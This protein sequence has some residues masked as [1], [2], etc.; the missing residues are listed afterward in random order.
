MINKVVQW[1]DDKFYPGVSDYWDDKLFRKKILAVLDSGSLLDLGAG[2]GILS[3]MNF[4]GIASKVT[5][6]DLDHRVLQNPY[7]DESHVVGG[8]VLPFQDEAFDVVV[9]DNVLEHLANPEQVFGEVQRVLRP[10][11]FFV[12]KTPNKSHYMPLIA[13]ITPHSFHEWFNRLRGRIEVDTFP[14][15]YRANSPMKIK[16]LA[17]KAG[18]EVV[19]IELIESRPEYL[20]FSAIPYFCGLIYERIVNSLPIFRLFRI[21]MIV[22]L[23][24]PELK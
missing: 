5:G 9:S 17:R 12:A 18:L 11:G 6:I 16:K 2:A 23:S 8:E 24:K 1:I 15:L 10:G 22:T 19:S 21:V 20:R 3:D 13:S 14:T 4:R 7:L